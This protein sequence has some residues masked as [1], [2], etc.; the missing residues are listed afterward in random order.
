[1]RQLRGQLLS[2]LMK[3]LT[4]EAAGVSAVL[5]L[6]S[7]LRGSAFQV[8]SL[9]SSCSGHLALLSEYNRFKVP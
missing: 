3:Q 6:M 9:G 5:V 2:Q 1:V 8:N 4:S 7:K